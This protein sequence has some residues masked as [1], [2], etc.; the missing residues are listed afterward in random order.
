MGVPEVAHLSLSRDFGRV[1]DSIWMLPFGFAPRVTATDNGDGRTAT[2][3]IRLLQESSS[4]SMNTTCD[5]VGTGL[6]MTEAGRLEGRLTEIT[7]RDQEGRA[8]HLTGLDVSAQSF[9][10]VAQAL[11]RGDGIS[12]TT[13]VE[14]FW[15]KVQVI[16]GGSDDDVTTLNLFRMHELK[17][18]NMG[19][20]ADFLHVDSST[21]A[22][23]VDG[24]VGNDTLQMHDEG[25]YTLDWSGV[26]GTGPRQVGGMTVRGFETVS[27]ISDEFHFIGSR[28]ADVIN[29]GA[30]QATLEGGLGN[31]TLSVTSGDATLYGGDG[32][33]VLII[34]NDCGACYGGAGNDLVDL[35]L[36]MS[37]RVVD[38]AA[39]RMWAIGHEAQTDH[40]IMG[41]ENVLGSHRADSITG[42]G[43]AN[44]LYGNA[45]D[46]RIEGGLGN[47][48]LGGGIG[49]D[50]LFGGGGNDSITGGV[51]NDRLSGG[52]G[53]DLLQGNAGNDALNARHGHDTLQG[54]AGDDRLVA[55]SGRA[56]L[57]GGTGADTFEIHPVTADDDWGRADIHDFSVAEG[58]RLVF[59]GI[60]G[61]SSR[62]DVLAHSLFIGNG[63]LTVMTD[64]G[65]TLTLQGLTAA[66]FD[67]AEIAFI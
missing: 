30:Y 25:S 6:R 59:A 67:R 37:G 36:Y 15:H 38:L 14:W 54:G 16:E 8:F 45:G 58:D 33:D 35:S 64:S 32:N 18:V 19:G 12:N 66:E 53:S 63:M 21:V 42:D 62:A 39:Q 55:T 28:G 24:G 4:F 47:D 5:L 61:L 46:D 41:I 60:D 9:L 29:T 2:I 44:R 22:L 43:V 27:V 57:T 49:N 51:G 10:R 40:P 34:E 48:N 52:F 7:L 1:F 13:F 17:S 23:T 50:A 11:S 31:D 65:A 56:S 20:G 26:T 3:S